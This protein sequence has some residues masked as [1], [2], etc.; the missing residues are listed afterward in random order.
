MSQNGLSL[1]ASA[2]APRPASRI[3]SGLPRRLIALAGRDTNI[4]VLF[5]ILN[6]MLRAV[7]SIVLTRLLMPE[8]FGISGILASITFTAA[9]VSDLGFQ[10]FVVRHEDGDRPRFLDTVWTISL[11]RSAALSLLLVALAEPIALLLDKPELAPLIAAYSLTFAIEGVASLTLLTALRNRMILRLSL[12]ELAVAVV[13]I[14][15]SA[16]FAYLWRTPW[17]IIVALLGSSALK[18]LLSYA[19]FAD[20]ARR[21]AFDRRYARDLWRFARFVTGSS[22][23]TLLLVQ[24]DKLVFA[25]FMPLDEFGFYILAGNLASAPLAF[26]TA[27]ASRVL[28]PSYSQLWRDGCA[29]LRAQFYAR[30]RLPSLLYSLATGGLI[31]C[32]PLVI[33]ILYD[34]RYADAGL[35]LRILA[36]MPLFALPSNAA[37]EALTATGR[38]RATFEASVVKLLWLGLMGPAAFLSEGIFGLVVVVALMEAP[39]LLFKWVLMHRAGLLDL[40][41]EMLFAGAAVAG[42]AAGAAGDFLLRPLSG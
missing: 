5:V 7:S 10:A 15:L 39:A 42:M 41:Q 33:A 35:Y 38:I 4:V 36:I 17:A 28:Y 12:L 2:P 21:L 40:R 6:N 1:P 31:G 30:R 24:C 23:I 8:V 3:M 9:M 22:I 14:L 19:M 26:T 27:Y 11:I 29:D 20:S 16:L 25:R 37:N 13:Q 34:P 18:S 32:A